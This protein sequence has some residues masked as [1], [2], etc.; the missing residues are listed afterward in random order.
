MYRTT[1]DYVQML[2]DQ[3]GLSSNY[4]VAK[5]LATTDS[6]VAAWTKGRSTFN[7]HT[8]LIIAKELKIDPLE[9]VTCCHIERAEKSGDIDVARVY[10]KMLFKLAGPVAAGLSAF[11]VGVFWSELSAPLLGPLA[12]V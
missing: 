4:Q 6:H 8:A 10:R 3:N 7:D 9:I 2:K 12:G 11:M 5:Y 1:A